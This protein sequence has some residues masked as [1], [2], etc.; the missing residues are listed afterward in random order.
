[1][2]TVDECSCTF[3]YRKVCFHPS[4]SDGNGLGVPC[5]GCQLNDL[6][7]TT[8]FDNEPIE[9]GIDEMLLEATAEK[10]EDEE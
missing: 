1:V 3:C 4:R 7:T 2:T 5:D 10:A 9:S 6:S 8:V